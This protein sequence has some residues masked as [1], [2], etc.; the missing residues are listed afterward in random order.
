MER[1][2]EYKPMSE[3]QLVAAFHKWK[4]RLMLEHWRLALRM[5]YSFSDVDAKEGG[6]LLGTCV[7]SF[8]DERATISIR[9]LKDPVWEAMYEGPEDTLLHEFCHILVAPLALDGPGDRNNEELLEHAVCKMTRVLKE[10]YNG[11]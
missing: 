7:Y 2:V 1:P 9:D 4:K 11:R 8:A 10:A 6:V 3:K 5:D